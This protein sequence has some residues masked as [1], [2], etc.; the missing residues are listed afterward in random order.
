[1]AR[2]DRARIR[3]VTYA[4]QP[5]TIKTSNEGTDVLIA[6]DHINDIPVGGPDHVHLWGLT[7]GDFRMHDLRH[8]AALFPNM[9]SEFQRPEGLDAQQDALVSRARSLAAGTIDKQSFEAAKALQAEW[10]AS[11]KASPANTHSFRA[12]MDEYFAKRKVEMDRRNAEWEKRKSEWATNKKAKERLVGQ[13]E[14]LAATTELRGSGQKM[15]ALF[16]EYKKVG[17]AGKADDDTLW[18]R[19]NNARTR[20]RQRND[21]AFEKRKSEWTRNKAAKESLVSRMR[22]LS[23]TWETRG[24]KDQARA[25]QDEWKTVGHCDRADEDN[26]WSQFKSAADIVYEKVKTANAQRAW[27]RV[28][29]LE[30]QVREAEA[31]VVRA[32]EFVSES[33][34][35]RTPSFTNPHFSEILARQSAKREKAERSL[36]K[37]QERLT[38]VVTWLHEAR[39]Q[40]NH[41]R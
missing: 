40:A 32:R 12:A 27:A 6:P 5:M 14:V 15:K 19:F 25:L 1:M 28:Q 11:G 34:N 38:R 24:L 37:A 9:R 4:G 26:L 35:T 2:W 29:N 3:H 7:N 33:L 36:R 18:E 21:E 17:P 41:S 22:A 8:H 10:K 30:M 23:N 39:D 13:A 20:L 16:E 31:S